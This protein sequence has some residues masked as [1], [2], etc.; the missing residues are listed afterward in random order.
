MKKEMALR[1]SLKERIKLYVLASVAP[2]ARVLSDVL[3]EEISA[4]KTLRILHVVIA[5]TALVFT[6][7]HALMSVLF[8]IW[9]ALTLVDCRRAGLK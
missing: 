7:G 4:E 9:F 2:M 6:Y 8:L 1:I 5:F 3:E